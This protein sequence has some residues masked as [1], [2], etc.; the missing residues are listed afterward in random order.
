[1]AI[2]NGVLALPAATAVRWA[3]TRPPGIRA[4]VGGAL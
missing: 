1:V 3:C 2:L 4:G